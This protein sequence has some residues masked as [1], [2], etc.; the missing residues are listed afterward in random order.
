MHDF[1][2]T[3]VLFLVLLFVLG[4][5]VLYKAFSTEQTG[6][7][8]FNSYTAALY[9]FTYLTYAIITSVFIAY[10]K[11]NNKINFLIMHLSVFLSCIFFTFLLSFFSDSINDQGDKAENISN[12]RNNQR[13]FV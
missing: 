4:I 3:H 5:W 6:L 11:I 7:I 10:L 12:I 1:I 9:W 8:D 13:L 2:K